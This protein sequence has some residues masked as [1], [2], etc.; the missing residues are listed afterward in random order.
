[1]NLP[2]DRFIHGY[3]KLLDAQVEHF[4]TDGISF[5][6]TPMR[7]RPEWSN[8][9]LPIWLFGFERAVICSTSS[10]YAEAVKAT[11]ADV[12]SAT[13]LDEVILARAMSIEPALEWVQ[14]D[15]FYYPYEQGPRVSHNYKVEKLQVGEPGA[16]KHLRNFDGG[17]YVIRG[18]QEEI[19]AA[20]FIKNK[21]L[22]REIAVGTED[23]YRR[24]GRGQAVVAY[25]IQELLAQDTLPT[26]WPDSLENKG[27]YAL[28][29]S[30]GM[31]KGA[32]MLF[33]A[34]EEPGWQGFA[35]T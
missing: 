19:T 3:A 21:G 34:Y 30:V 20:A 28:A 11:F 31:V 22:I 16:A 14:C 32:E 9:I 12:T 24:Q 5:I 26:Y 4:Y 2:V 7:D 8:W 15:L 13:L 27:S 25:A 6:S 33:C 1:M 10:I 17:V 35:A 18:E 23:P 29:H